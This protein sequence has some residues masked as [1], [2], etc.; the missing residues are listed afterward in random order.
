MN[1][2]GDAVF[3]TPA[4]NASSWVR[5]SVPF[6][7][8]DTSAPAYVMVNITSSDDQNTSVAGSKLWVDD[9]TMIYNPTSVNN[10]TS[11]EQN[12]KAYS[13]NKIFYIDFL[14]RNNSESTVSV[15]DLNGR[16]IIS[17][18]ITNNNLH[19][20]DMSRYNSG[21]YLY[22]IC[23]NGMTKSGKFFVD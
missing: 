18:T 7:Y 3:T 1:K 20:F 17:G 5:F 11:L 6:V 2:I 4:A 21:I 10:V 13:Y 9:L 23:S 15:Y 8:A 14:N 19:S 22:R 12:S 16:K